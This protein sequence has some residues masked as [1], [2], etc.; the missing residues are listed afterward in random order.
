VEA[1]LVE[2]AGGV[3]DVVADGRLL[4]SKRATGGFPESA[5]IVEKLRAGR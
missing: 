2:G 4:H 3:F 1:E 5:A